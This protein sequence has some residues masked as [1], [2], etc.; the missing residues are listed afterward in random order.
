SISRTTKSK[1][2]IN[3]SMI[4]LSQL[5]SEKSIASIGSLGFIHE[6]CAFIKKY[7]TDK[8][9]FKNC[10]KALWSAC[11]NES[12]AELA[13]QEN[14]L[15]D[16]FDGASRFNNDPSVATEVVSLYWALSLEDACEKQILESAVPGIFIALQ[17]HRKDVKVVRACFMALTSIASC[18]EAA[19]KKILNPSSS[20]KKVN[21]LMVFV[22]VVK[23][24]SGDKQGMEEFV[25]LVDEL[26]QEDSVKDQ[27]KKCK[28]LKSELKKLLTKYKNM[29][30]L[31]EII[32]AL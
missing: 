10:V 27:L 9:V 20:E 7:K 12:N 13:S 23:E 21:G 3:E 1:D 19:C 29:E 22:A 32:S 4:V 18:G 31:C 15:T 16:I 6:I 8:E 17:L 11:V 30:K 24:Q 26:I 2:I 25:M 28:P 14:I 5:N